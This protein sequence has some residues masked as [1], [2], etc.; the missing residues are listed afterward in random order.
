MAMDVMEGPEDA[1][2]SRWGREGDRHS[3]PRAQ[4]HSDLEACELRRPQMSTPKI[5]VGRSQVRLRNSSVWLLYLCILGE[6]LMR[7]YP[8][9]SRSFSKL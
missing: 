2:L 8:L 3:I 7:L 5:F 1:L 4:G 6:M 9:P